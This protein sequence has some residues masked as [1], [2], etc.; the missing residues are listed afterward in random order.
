MEAVLPWEGAV[1]SH[2][3]SPSKGVCQPLPVAHG[4]LSADTLGFCCI[5]LSNPCD[6]PALLLTVPRESPQMCP[7]LCWQEVLQDGVA[8]R[9]HEGSELRK[10]L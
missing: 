7:H 9:P 2:G 6:Q 10:G 1:T 4:G 8:L 3:A 5:L